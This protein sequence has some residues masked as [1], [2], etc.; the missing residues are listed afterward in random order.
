MEVSILQ[1][2]ANDNPESPQDIEYQPIESEHGT[3]P[4]DNYQEQIQRMSN[5]S[6]WAF[7]HNLLL[8]TRP[9]ADMTHKPLYAKHIE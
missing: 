8:F 7:R 2:R 6:I 1:I 3:R 5:P 9:I 4:D